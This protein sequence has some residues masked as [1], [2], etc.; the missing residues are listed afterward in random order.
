M[1]GI[2]D[3]GKDE[4]IDLAQIFRR[5]VAVLSLD[6]MLLI[7]VDRSRNRR[8]QHVCRKRCVAY[9]HVTQ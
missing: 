5:D 1:E 7:E 9:V 6:V 4:A 8:T 3:S 2:E